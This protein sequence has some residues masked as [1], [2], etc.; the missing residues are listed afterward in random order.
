[1]GGINSSLDSL[2]KGEAHGGLDVGIL[3]VQRGVSLEGLGSQ[4]AVLVGDNGEVADGVD[5]GGSLDACMSRSEGKSKQKG[6]SEQKMQAAGN[7]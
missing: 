7:H 1:M 5:G 2:V 3:G 4:R 6:K